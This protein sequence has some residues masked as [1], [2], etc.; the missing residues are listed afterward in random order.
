MDWF[1]KVNVTNPYFPLR[2][3]I[4]GTIYKSK[5]KLQQDIAVKLQALQPPFNELQPHPDD[6]YIVEALCIK[7]GQICVA[8]GQSLDS[9]TYIP[10]NTLLA[11]ELFKWRIPIEQV[12][13]R[14]MPSLTVDE[15]RVRER[16]SRE[17]YK[18]FE[19]FHDQETSWYDRIYF[20]DHWMMGLL[21][22]G[23]PAL[24]ENIK[25]EEEDRRKHREG[26]VEED[27]ANAVAA[28]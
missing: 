9:I 22:A 11:S 27:P 7:N 4:V 26:F 8:N 5:N 24:V 21:K 2:Q 14:M 25:K 20:F 28:E 13:E 16:L 19:E 1:A 3:I 10:G 12:R 6:T 17:F 18:Q 23:L 15:K